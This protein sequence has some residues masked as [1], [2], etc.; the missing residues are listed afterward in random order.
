M[1]DAS[2]GIWYTSIYL[3]YHVRVIYMFECVH[4][5]N[6]SIYRDHS[7]CWE[8]LASKKLRMRGTMQLCSFYY[9][10]LVYAYC[11]QLINHSVSSFS[12]W[13]APVFLCTGGDPTDR[14]MKELNP[15]SLY[16]TENGPGRLHRFAIF[17]SPRSSTWIKPQWTAS[18]GA[19]D[20]IDLSSCSW[21]NW[22]DWIIQLNAR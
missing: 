2:L 3:H 10:V 11:K 12:I 4:S 20:R 9:F 15:Y 21:T 22:I 8:L 18:R 17:W 14:L 5:C 1:P 7:Q 16:T 13:R 19:A 6:N